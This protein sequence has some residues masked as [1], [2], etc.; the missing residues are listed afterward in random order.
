[1]YLHQCTHVPLPAD[2][3][4]A[5]LAFAAVPLDAQRRWHIQHLL[6]HA[7][8]FSLPAW[9]ELQAVWCWAFHRF[10]AVADTQHAA[11]AA[12]LFDLHA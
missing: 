1:M 6:V 9:P 8:T 11:T 2:R 3:M 10:G 12:Q 7:H 5:A 4:H